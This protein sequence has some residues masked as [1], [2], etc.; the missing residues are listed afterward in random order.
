LDYFY[1]SRGI[2]NWD[3]RMEHG[4]Q[5]VVPGD[6]SPVYFNSLDDPIR[7][8]FTGTPVFV[9]VLTEQAPIITPNDQAALDALTQAGVISR[10]G[11]KFGPGL[12]I[13][14]LDLSVDS[15]TL[16]VRWGQGGFDTPLPEANYGFTGTSLPT[17]GS[18]DD[19]QSYHLGQGIEAF[20]FAD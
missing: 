6:G 1:W 20:E 17:F 8:I 11:V 18:L 7:Q 2:L 5:Y 10:G 15:G 19:L 16:S 12:T 4:G 13:A 14:D 9:P 3:E